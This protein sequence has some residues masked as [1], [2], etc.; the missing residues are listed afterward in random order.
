MIELPLKHID[1]LIEALTEGNGEV[2]KGYDMGPDLNIPILTIYFVNV[3]GNHYLIL[4]DNKSMKVV[5][6]SISISS[7]ISADHIFRTA[8]GTLVLIDPFVEGGVRYLHI[9]EFFPTYYKYLI[10]YMKYTWDYESYIYELIR[11]L[12]NPYR[13][14]DSNSIKDIHIKYRDDRERIESLIN[15]YP[16]K[17]LWKGELDN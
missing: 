9:D 12:F 11:V 14:H 2:I 1:S 8:Y 16:D 13:I 17:Y 10:G 15:E 4:V 3:L 6:R 7:L 5:G